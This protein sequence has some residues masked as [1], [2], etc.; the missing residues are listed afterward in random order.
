MHDESDIFLV[1]AHPERR[2][3]DNDVVSF[4]AGDPFPL[5]LCSL[6][7]AQPGVVGCCAD[8]LGAEPLGERRAF[9]AGGGVDDA[10]DGGGALLRLG[11]F[12][13]AGGIVGAAGVDCTEPG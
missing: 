8:G 1:D 12:E 9:G 4:F 7:G 13:R 5:A 2:R 10:A 3:R 6:E 11:E